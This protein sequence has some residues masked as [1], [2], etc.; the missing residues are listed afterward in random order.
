MSQAVMPDL[1]R[2]I[3]RQLRGAIE[4][5]A[6]ISE[7][8]VKAS[9]SRPGSPVPF[10]ASQPGEPPTDWYGNVIAGIHTEVFE[11]AH[12]IGFRLFSTA[13]DS[14]RHVGEHISY[15]I[16]IGG[17]WWSGKAYDPKDGKV[18]QVAPPHEVAARPFMGPEVDIWKEEG[19]AA[20]GSL[21]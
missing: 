7:D 12:G 17:F 2:A 19:L 20:L 6:H 4:E 21:M 8:R 14:Y 10:V 3:R 18:K 9:L 11:D 13:V 1:E 5:Y 15:R 16:E